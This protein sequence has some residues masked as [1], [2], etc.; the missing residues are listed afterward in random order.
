MKNTDYTIEALLEN[1]GD[2]LYN[3]A[4]LKVGDAEAAADLVQDTFEAAIKGY[5]TFRGESK[6][7][8]WLFGILRNK[9]MDFYKAKYKAQ[10]QLRQDEEEDLAQYFTPEGAW[11]PEA[12]PQ[13]ATPH[14]L[15]QPEFLK[16]LYR[17][18]DKL[19][20]LWKA[21]LESKYLREKET[22]ALCQELNI[23]AT[24]YWQVNRRAKLAMQQCLQA[25]W[26]K[27]I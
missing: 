1:H 6:S 7:R 5:A 17:C 25:N 12:V 8:T 9:I 27:L 24:N 26:F 15:D 22:T 4:R 14:L 2:A 18:M 23:S 19:P 3:Y 20:S 10:G 11:R 21:V 13:P 16:T